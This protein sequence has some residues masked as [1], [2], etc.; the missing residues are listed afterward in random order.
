MAP[1]IRF[2][3][4]GLAYVEAFTAAHR[5]AANKYAREEQ[6]L[7]VQFPAALVAPH[8][9]DWFAGK[10]T[11][12][13]VGYS[14]QYGGMGYYADFFRWPAADNPKG[15]T[16]EECLRWD[17]LRE[18]WKREDAMH[19]C[20]AGYAPEYA[21]WLQGIFTGVGIYDQAAYALYRMA[22]LQLDLRKLVTLGLRGLE[23]E[24]D[25]RLETAIDAEARA[26]LG[27]CRHA[28]L[29]FRQSIQHYIDAAGALP[30]SPNRDAMIAALEHVKDA[31][32]ESFHQALQLVMLSSAMTGTINF[33]RL[34]VVLGDFLC[35]D[36]DAGRLS[37]AHAKVLLANF[38]VLIEEE[39][40]QWDGRI[41][42]GGR[43]RENEQAANRFAM[44]AMEVTDSLCLPMPQLSLRFYEGQDPALLDKAYDVIAH[45]KTFPML[46]NDDVN[47]PAVMASFKVDAATATQYVPYGCGEYMIYHQS[48]HTPNG[49][50]NLMKCLEATLNNG[51][52]LSTGAILAPDVGSLADYETF[53]DL[54][55]AYDKTVSFFGKALGHAQDM[56]YKVMGQTAPFGL[57]SLLYDDCLARGRP[58][59]GGGIRVLGGTCETY[60]N[61]NCADSL[62]ALKQCLYDSGKWQ[63]AD[64]LAAL[65]DNWQGHELMQRD[66][67]K[68]PKYGNDHDV[69][70]AMFLRVH[71][72]VC[73]R[74]KEG[75]SGTALDHFLVVVINNK[76]NTVWGAA[77]SASP[78]SRVAGE[79]LAP[80]NA[81][82]GGHDV[83]GLTA[84]L[85]SQAKPDP[86]IH[87]GAVQNVK[88]NM[89]FP[90]QHPQLY[91]T[92]FDTYFKQGGAQIMVTVTN[93]A[94]LE[95]A[96]LEPAKYPHL[97]VRVGGFSARFIDL[98]PATQTEILSRTEHG[99]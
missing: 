49:I 23:Q 79:A 25:V 10:R 34:D 62:V 91:R 55:F 54:W 82:G 85:N 68:A 81:P 60:A 87:A 50:I 43:G 7:K 15:Y 94:D 75:A 37:W 18:Y 24:I 20:L 9:T 17:V 89:A 44:L 48:C 14:V 96:V 74:V 72:H 52:S 39:I 93:R 28:I 63:R 22:G 56:T 36:L 11:Y 29:V 1:I 99:I 84:V 35:D 65:R 42:V 16:P 61:T 97:L 80:G 46:Y 4:L 12:P 67:R 2:K 38:Y 30:P 76:I 64:L 57:V 40:M 77:T 3:P 59:F 86:T 51:R 90:A 73:R 58:L 66:F 26:F 98:D 32:P 71:N 31:P 47:I 95:A 13:E 33:G 27:T 92:V 19:Q 69:A 41:I 70:D 45:G 88:L 21:D 5:S 6:C 53:E 83:S 8:A 78:D